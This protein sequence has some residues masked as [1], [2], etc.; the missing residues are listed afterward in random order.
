MQ[1][2]ETTS[3]SASLG[4]PS[5]LN[6]ERV[7]RESLQ[8]NDSGISEDNFNEGP[9]LRLLF[10]HVKNMANQQYELN[11]AIIAILSKLALLPHPYLHEILLNPEIP[12]APGATTLWMC[13]QSLAKQL[14]LEIPRIENFQQK[15]ADTGKRLLTNPPMISENDEEADP[16]FEAIIV[17]EE[18][19]KELAAIAFVKY[20]H[21]TE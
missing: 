1:S 9:L 16:M 14:L 17:L 12:V 6:V 2:P 3:P 21:A 15:I 19:C 8:C 7:K 18:F 13:L 20:H 10:N 5:A 4:L 11:L